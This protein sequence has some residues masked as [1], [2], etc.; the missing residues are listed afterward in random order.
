MNQ[1]LII[2]D[3]PEI[4]GLLGA[5]LEGIGGIQFFG[6]SNGLEAL[7][8][9]KDETKTPQMV[10]SDLDMPELDGFRLL[11]EISNS[12]KNIPVFIITG[13]NLSEKELAWLQSQSAFRGI[14]KKPF[15]LKELREKIKENL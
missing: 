13:G 3:S 6:A 2:D 8:I 7:E 9:M 12:G 5:F 10:I 15:S 4:L 11:Q 14:L 1:V